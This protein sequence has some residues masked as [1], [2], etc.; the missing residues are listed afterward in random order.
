[1]NTLTYL[2]INL[3]QWHVG[4]TCTRRFLISNELYHMMGVSYK[5]ACLTVISELAFA[6]I[7]VKTFNFLTANIYINSNRSLGYNRVK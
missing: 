3:R 7:S 1:M 5:S 6:G 4:Y 2:C